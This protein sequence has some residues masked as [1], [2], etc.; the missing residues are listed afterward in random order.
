VSRLRDAA[1][2]ETRIGKAGRKAEKKTLDAM[3]AQPTPNSG[4]SGS[5]GDGELLG[6][7]M[8]CKSTIHESISVKREHLSKIL[9]EAQAAGVHPCLSII[10]TDGSGRPF[11]EGTWICIPQDVFEE[12]TSG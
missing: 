2:G 9:G 6:F 1:A 12:L 5:K 3:G 7:L 8:E 11:R 10:F 4:A